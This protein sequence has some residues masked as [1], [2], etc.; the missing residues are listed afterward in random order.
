M[1]RLQPSSKILTRRLPTRVMVM[2]G[3]ALGLIAGVTAFGAMS[4]PAQATMPAAY[5]TA[6]PTVTATPNFALCAAGSKLEDGVC[7][8]HVVRTVE[9]PASATSSGAAA[10]SAGTLTPAAVAEPPKAAAAPA[11]RT[12]A[13]AAK[14]S[15]SDDEHSSSSSKSSTPTPRDTGGTSHNND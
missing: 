2:G 9:A 15:E 14:A 12:T 13:E 3:A 6:K 8:V 10:T 1:N 4:D 7:V 11:A 5:T